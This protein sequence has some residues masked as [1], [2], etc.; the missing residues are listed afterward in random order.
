MVIG[1]LRSIW[2]RHFHSEDMCAPL[3]DKQGKCE[4]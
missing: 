1:A 4:A 2:H 3:F